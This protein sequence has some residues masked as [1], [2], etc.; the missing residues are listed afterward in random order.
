MDDWV[1]VPLFT[2][3]FPLLVFLLFCLNIL[4]QNPFVLR[5]VNELHGEN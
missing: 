1:F 5:K 3:Q 2:L 4:T